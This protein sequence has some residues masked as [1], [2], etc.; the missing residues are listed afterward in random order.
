MRIIILTTVGLF[1]LVSYADAKPRHYR[2]QVT[3]VHSMFGVDY[4]KKPAKTLWQQEFQKPEGI[5]T[6]YQP[7]IG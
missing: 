2:P 6:T 4:G 3:P 1:A 7:D 5:Q